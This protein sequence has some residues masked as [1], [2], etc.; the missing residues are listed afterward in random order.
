MN[1]VLLISPLFY[2]EKGGSQQYMEEIYGAMIKR[3]PEISV[4]VLCYNTTNTKEFEVLRGLNIHRLP[5]WNI[6]P[7][8]FA[9]SNPFSLL[10]FLY[11]NRHGYDLIHCSTRF[12]DSSWWAPIYAKI[13]GKKIVLTDHC[14]DFPVHS[15][16]LTSWFA[17]AIDLTIDRIA[18]NFFDKIF[19]TNKATQKF[20]EKTFNKSPEII[21]G[22]VDYTIFK[23]QTEHI[24]TRLKVLFV[25]RMIDSKGVKILFEIARNF[26]DV[27]FIFAGPGPLV[28]V[29]KSEVK[30]LNIKNI[31]ILGSMDKQDVAR[32]MQESDIL[33][34]P[35]YHHE[36]FPN[37]LT[38]AGG[39][40]IAVIATDIGGTGEI[41]I[42]QKTGLL[43]EPKNSEQLKEA[44][45]RLITDKE[46]REKLADGLYKHVRASFEWRKASEQ[47]YLE[48]KTLI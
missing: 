12:F 1:K 46:L 22:G 21:Y 32:L 18:L 48:L 13:I 9:L 26:P 28:E 25:G 10:K 36:G 35:S 16:K 20:S 47:L 33:V 11:I 19:V 45:L 42:N 40:K 29:L 39:S 24:N 7:G 37:V 8:Q 43:I 15:N 41:I 31:E 44:L 4:D 38:E 30:E 5:S 34:H 3:H 17:K 6:L 27:D 23:P 2:P 14:A